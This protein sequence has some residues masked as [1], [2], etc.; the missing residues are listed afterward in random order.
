MA[1]PSAEK[2][3]ATRA[4]GNDVPLPPVARTAGSLER[5]ACGAGGDAQARR[6]GRLAQGGDA[7]RAVCTHGERDVGPAAA[8]GEHLVGAED[9]V[10]TRG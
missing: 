4:P 10:L 7:H 1:V 2:A 8:A 3:V 5:S 9:G 6:A